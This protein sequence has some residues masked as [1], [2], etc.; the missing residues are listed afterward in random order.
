MRG[1]KMP[2]SEPDEVRA[3]HLTRQELLRRAA[4]GAA[5]LATSGGL[6]DALARPTSARA[7]SATAAAGLPKRGGTLRVGMLGGTSGDTL[8]PDAG[9][10]FMDNIRAPA[11]F[12]PLVT[13]NLA[14]TGVTYM[15]AE[16]MTA[17]KDAKS[18]TIRLRPDVT[19][20]NGKPLTADDVIYTFRRIADPKHPLDGSQNLAAID[21]TGLRAVDSHTVFVPMKTPFASFP[22]QISNSYNFGI[23]PVG[24]DATNPI[25]TGPFT[26]KSLTP[27][28]Q[29]VFVRNNN[30]WQSG[31]P[32]LD[33]ITII[34]FND[35]TAAF[36]A[37]QSGQIDMYANAQSTLIG[38]A[39]SAGLEVLFSRAGQWNLLCMRVD[40]PPFT[41]VRVRQAFKLIV[42]RPQIN[43]QA[44][45]GHSAIGNDVFGQFDA[46][47][48][49]TL[50]HHQDIARAKSLLKAA[51]HGSG[52]SLE[53]VTAPVAAGQ[54]DMSV[55][56]A[57]Q[58]K[59]AGVNIKLRKVP[60][61]T[62]YGP[63]YKKWLFSTNAESYN[64]YLTGVA[65][66]TLTTSPYNSTHF[67]NPRYDSLY[68]QANATLNHKLSTEIQHEMQ[69]IDF[70]TGGFIIPTYNKLVDIHTKAVQGLQ[71]AALCLPA[72]NALWADMWLSS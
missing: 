32:Y 37:V 56:F 4:G 11:L 29:S 2:L 50:K 66:F 34:D 7:Y 13:L 26:Y 1:D 31:K 25:G 36:N 12:D 41:D 30:Y 15:L 22:L 48:D 14:G 39:T 5:L 49:K 40:K 54:V 72:G 69:R 68:K 47:F 38:P 23:V 35:D 52:L 33:Q 60:V 67:S 71:S 45:S 21:L 27:G 19:F 16:S 64:A 59:A 57:Q 63:Q 43:S 20:H 6:F 51:G 53:L 9:A 18:W 28:Q 17:S 24:F 44:Y 55:V 10:N 62:L 42:N 65:L 8:D 3:G 46:S 58:A 70:D 61:G